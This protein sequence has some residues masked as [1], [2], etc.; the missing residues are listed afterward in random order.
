MPGF[1]IQ[2]Q[3]ADG[4]NAQTEVRRKHRWTLEVPAELDQG[5]N[6]A[7]LWLA[8]AARPKIK[9]EE[10]IAHHDQERAY[11]AGRT[12]WDPLSVSFYDAEQSPDVSKFVWNWVNTVVDI[13]GVVAKNPGAVDGG[14]E[15]GY[16][17]KG[18]LNMWGADGEVTETWELLNC[19]PQQTNWGDLDYSSSEIAMIEMT[20]R[21]D[22]AVRVTD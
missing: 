12:E 10:A 1:N 5:Q 14:A 17:K 6:R 4:P 8:K 2:G 15:G 19:W 11:W 18:E 9:F 22:R 21:F 16:K 7:V 13:E 3:W 20:I